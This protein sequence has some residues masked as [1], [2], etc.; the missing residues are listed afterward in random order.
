MITNNIHLQEQIL[1]FIPDVILKVRKTNQK[2]LDLPTN[3]GQ[4]LCIPRGYAGLTKGVTMSHTFD[5]HH[6]EN[7]TY[8]VTL[9][10]GDN[11]QLCLLTSSTKTEYE[12]ICTL[13]QMAL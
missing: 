5:V 9:A 3:A 1:E 7:F 8:W 2:M 13:K 4:S 10:D 12:D 6:G 11:Y